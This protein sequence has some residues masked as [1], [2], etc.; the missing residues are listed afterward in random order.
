MFVLYVIS[1][2]KPYLG[3]RCYHLNHIS[4]F[5][6]VSYFVDLF[7]VMFGSFQSNSSIKWAGGSVTKLGFVTFTHIRGPLFFHLTVLL[8]M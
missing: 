5:T 2:F 4:V 8:F 1:K 3:I 7:R 6:V